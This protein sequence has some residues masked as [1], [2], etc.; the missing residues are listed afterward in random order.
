MEEKIL[1]V[2]PE[3]QKTL[4]YKMYV[5]SVKLAKHLKKSDEGGRRRERLPLVFTGGVEVMTLEELRENFDIESICA[6]WENGELEAWLRARYYDDIASEVERL[7]PAEEDMKARLYEI[8]E[9]ESPE[10][11]AQS[12]LL[13]EVHEEKIRKLKEFTTDCKFEMVV[14]KIAF[15]QEELYCLLDMG[16]KEIYLC[17]EKFEVPFGARNVKYIGVNEPLV[18]FYTQERINLEKDKGI[19][20]ENVKFGRTELEHHVNSYLLGG[21]GEPRLAAEYREQLRELLKNG[22]FSIPFNMLWAKV[23]YQVGETTFLDVV[24]RYGKNEKIECR[25]KGIGMYDKELKFFYKE[26]FG[27]KK[28]I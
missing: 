17:G 28:N 15:T 1:T 25:D 23:M 27:R 12:S 26:L 16:E 2:T 4:M 3:V 19:V 20:F 18:T 14:D 5:D 10:M 21:C 22:G 9:I 8:F 11:I 6:Y 13:E 7:N 24:Y